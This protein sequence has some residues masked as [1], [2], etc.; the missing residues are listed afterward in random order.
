MRQATIKLPSPQLKGEVSLEEAIAKRRSVR[1]YRQ[2]PLDLCQLSQ[3]LWAAQ[4]LTGTRGSRAA[5]SAGATYP[6]EILVLVGRQGVIAGKATHTPEVLPAGLYRYEANSHSLSLHKPADLRPHLARAALNQE[7]LLEAP[8]DIVICALYHRTCHRYGQRGER[9]VHIEAGHVAEN[10]HLQAVAL[11][12]ATVEVG[13][14]H[15]EDVRKT[16]GVEEEV[17]P[18]YIM[19]L[20]KAV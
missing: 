18:L 8:V 10:I 19:P 17:K 15:D 12:L 20:G 7:F 6:L 16:L 11:G 9:Y 3:I 14:F 5:P 1:R 13:A 4:G 2:E